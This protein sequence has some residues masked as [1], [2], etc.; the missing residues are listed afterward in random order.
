MSLDA[1]LLPLQR[2]LNKEY[3]FPLDIISNRNSE[4]HSE[5]S[6]RLN[7][8]IKNHYQHYLTTQVRLSEDN[9]VSCNHQKKY[10]S[11]I[12]YLIS[13]YDSYQKYV[14]QTKNKANGTL[15]ILGKA[16]IHKLA[17]LNSC[18]ELTL[19][20]ESLL[21]REMKVNFKSSQRQ[22][23]GIVLKNDE[24]RLVNELEQ[25]SQSLWPQIDTIKNRY[26][27]RLVAIPDILLPL[28]QIALESMSTF[29]LHHIAK[30]FDSNHSLIAVENKEK[31]EALF[32]MLSYIISAYP[33]F[34][35]ARC[36]GKCYL[37][38]AQYHVKDKCLVLFSAFDNA[39][40][41]RV[42]SIGYDILSLSQDKRFINAAIDLAK[43]KYQQVCQGN[44]EHV[45]KVTVREIS[46]YLKN[47]GR[48]LIEI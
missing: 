23:T 14:C 39:S 1:E 45:K 22:T 40:S 31:D 42:T 33:K 5:I 18:S 37:I 11:E 12:N 19:A 25:L 20:P 6:S 21:K 48:Q 8:Y 16:R 35:S 27:A 44:P 43:F 41:A 47:L 7:N 13:V 17:V 28:Y 46:A 15:S 30:V 4:C 3:K 24:C 36:L 32:T 2:N 38:T 29:P 9:S 34:L 26:K 10:N